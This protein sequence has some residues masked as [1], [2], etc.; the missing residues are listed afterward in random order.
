MMATFLVSETCPPTHAF[1]YDHGFSCCAHFVRASSTIKELQI[2]DPIEE[3]EPSRRIECPHLPWRLCG[4]DNVTKSKPIT[5]SL[6]V[7]FDQIYFLTTAEPC[8]APNFWAFENGCCSSPERTLD[9]S[10]PVCDRGTLL[11]TDPEAC[12]QDPVIVD[13]CK[14][15]ER[16][17]STGTGLEMF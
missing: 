8:Q 2:S 6:R 4:N 16:I 7:K 13:A 14:N 9:A 1:A 5:L 15:K 11:P 12:C 3:C 17:C 10:N